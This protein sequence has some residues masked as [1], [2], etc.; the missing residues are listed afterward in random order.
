MESIVSSVDIA[1]RVCAVMIRS[2][3]GRSGRDVVATRFRSFS[4]R[5]ARP[6]VPKGRYRDH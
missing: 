5:P 2:G 1:V 6:I 4:L 3:G